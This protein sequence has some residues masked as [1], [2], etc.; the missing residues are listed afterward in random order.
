MSFKGSPSFYFAEILKITLQKVK[1]K[2][3][4]I[5]LVG[6]RYVLF[7]KNPKY[8]YIGKYQFGFGI[9]VKFLNFWTQE[10]LAVIN[11]KFTQRCQT[12]GY[13]TKKMQMEKQK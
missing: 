10:N 6:K 13:F 2:Q 1:G 4:G 3:L 5:K 11:L 7:S 12:L 8:C 9:T